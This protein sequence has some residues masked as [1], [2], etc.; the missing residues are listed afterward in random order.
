MITAI[1]AKTREEL[2]DVV[3]RL[4]DTEMKYG[5]EIN[6]DISQVLRVSRRNE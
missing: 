3:S 2:Q 4:V 6:N 5:L 1:I